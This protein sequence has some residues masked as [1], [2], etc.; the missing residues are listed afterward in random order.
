M[1]SWLQLSTNATDVALGLA[2][3]ASKK[4]IAAA[5]VIAERKGLR[6]GMKIGLELSQ[7]TPLAKVVPYAT[8]VAIATTV[9][10][11]FLRAERVKPDNKNS[12][13]HLESKLPVKHAI[14]SSQ[15]RS[16]L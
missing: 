16:A 10:C 4:A 9:I 1:P 3:V 8:T 2:E 7:A 13:A 5:E 14:A 6:E 12:A 11:P 15:I